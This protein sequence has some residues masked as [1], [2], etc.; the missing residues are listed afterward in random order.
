ILWWRWKRMLE[1][2]VKWPGG[3]RWLVQQCGPLFPS[4]YARYIEPFLGGGAVF[5]HL[6]PRRAILS[7]TNCELVNAY[8]CLRREVD[9]ICS[10]LSDLHLR[11]NKT[12]Y[13]HIRDMNPTSP[14]EK[15][16]RFLYLNRTCFN[17]IYRVNLKGEFNVP[18]GTK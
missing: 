6:S 1:P 16:I 7:D 15:A 12:L 4:T 2:F 18:I 8:K 17:G 13:Y 11:H 14:V 9:V 5:F 3:K 10:R